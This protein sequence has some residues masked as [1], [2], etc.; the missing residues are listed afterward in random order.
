MADD[1]TDI[2]HRLFPRSAKTKYDH[3]RAAYCIRSDYLGTVPRFDGREFQS[4]FRLSRSRFQRLMEDVAALQDPFYVSTVDGTGQTGASFEARLMLPLKTMAYGVPPH[5]F[6]DY[7]QMSKTLAKTCCKKFHQ[8]IKSIHEHEY[9]RLPTKE[10]LKNVV[11]LHEAVHEVNRM[12]GSLDC[13][14]TYWKNC[15]TAWK[16]QFKGKEKHCTIVLEAAC[17]HHL[18]F[19]H[20]AYGFA[21][22]LNDINILNMSPLLTRILNGTFEELESPAVPH[23]IGEEEFN[24]LFFLVDGIYPSLSRFIKAIKAPIYDDE[25]S[26]TAWQ[27]SARKDIERAFGVL[28]CQWQC[29]SRP[30]HLMKMESIATM[31]AASLILHNM[32]VSDRV[33]NGDVRARY[34]PANNL[35]KDNMD[36]NGV[37]Q[38]YDLQRNQQR[39]NSSTNAAVTHVAGNRDV[40]NLVRKTRFDAPN[41]EEAQAR[42]DKLYNYEENQRLL[43]ALKEL[44]A[45]SE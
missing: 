20:A 36:E 34:N 23:K 10:D 40:Y 41:D 16:G 7:F 9:L 30:I 17:D 32:G 15:P 8:V 18:W 1:A 33:M 14:H 11:R 37:N 3:E 42:W 22:T 43:G 4:M 24:Q 45:R 5:C 28:Q 26:F 2:D 12:F 25:K 29:V 27:E 19:W 38:P 13:M 21:G 44:K 39:T 35:Q 31:I 6:R